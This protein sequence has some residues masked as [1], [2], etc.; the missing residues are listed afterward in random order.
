M[1]GS[2]TRNAN[3]DYQATMKYSRTFTFLLLMVALIGTPIEFA[4]VASAH[5]DKHARKASGPV[6]ER[7]IAANPSVAL[8]LCIASGDIKVHGWDRNEVRA[9]SND[10]PE[11]EFRRPA[12]ARDSDP[13]REITVM[14]ADRT[15]RRDGSCSFEG[16]IELDVPR[17]ASVR[18]QTRDGDIQVADVSTVS[19]NT[20][21]GDLDL[22]GVK[23]S[24]EAHT[25]GGNISLRNSTGSAELHSVGGTIEAGGVGPAVAGD[26]FEAA[27]V[28]GDIRLDKTSFV[29]LVARTVSGD[30]SLSGP[31][32]VGGRYEFKTISGDVSLT[33]PADS[34]FRLDAKLSRDTELVTDFPLRMTS[35][36]SA[37][38]S[39]SSRRTG[40]PEKGDAMIDPDTLV[41]GSGYSL[42]HISGVYGSGN[43]LITVSSFSGAINLRKK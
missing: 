4:V 40:P 11:I 25:I 39:Q 13:A 37:A 14:I 28:G 15:P 29:E 32:A 24:A 21:A 2:S 36:L 12:G 9:R 41:K 30:L 23:R 34:S 22:A 6:I 1:H 26:A 10:A 16:E 7:V 33:L 5:P 35:G 19:A 8:S 3:R 18:L 27:T 20:Q 17:G 31:L 42:Q 43:A 38:P